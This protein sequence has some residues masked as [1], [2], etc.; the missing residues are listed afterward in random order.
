MAFIKSVAKLFGRQ[1]PESAS[2]PN[3]IWYMNT[4]LWQSAGS[5]ADAPPWLVFPNSPEPEDIVLTGR[6]GNNEVYL[7]LWWSFWNPLASDAKLSYLKEHHAP[8]V[9]VQ[10][11]K[12]GGDRDH[13]EAIWDSLPK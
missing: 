2:N 4:Q 5:M 7:D 8:P 13:V 12:P 6:Q 3:S 9:W 1:D 10:Y 11:L